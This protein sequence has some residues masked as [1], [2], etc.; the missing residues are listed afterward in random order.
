MANSKNKNGS[1]P[2]DQE[3]IDQVQ[4]GSKVTSPEGD[5][6]L[7]LRGEEGRVQPEEGS[8]V[9]A[10]AVDKKASKKPTKS[11]AKKT[12]E[13]KTA[14]AKAAP[15]ANIVYVGEDEPTRKINGVFR[16]SLPEEAEQ[17]AGFFHKDARRII[18]LFPKL[19]ERP[20]SSERSK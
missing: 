19:Y 17:R 18:A 5:A 3:T 9:A 10:R 8:V 11:A 16:A 1:A 13:K 2:V 14:K 15:D 12:T 20:G 7:N 6:V 4:A